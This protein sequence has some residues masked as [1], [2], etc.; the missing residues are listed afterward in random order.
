MPPEPY[1]SRNNGFTLPELMVTV[2]IGI[3]L[4]AG[5]AIMF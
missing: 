3:G 1:T 2:L 4:M 5:M